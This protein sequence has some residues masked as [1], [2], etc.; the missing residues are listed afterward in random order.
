MKKAL[1]VLIGITLIAASGFK[2]YSSTTEGTKDTDSKN[3]VIS[4][5]ADSFKDKVFNYEEG[6]QWNYKGDVPAILDFYADWCGPCKMLSPVLNKIQKEYDG[7]L[8]IYKIN[9]DEQRELAATFGIRSLPTIVFV[10]MD[11]EPQATMGYH[12]KDDLEEMIT[13]ILQVEK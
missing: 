4:L 5:D 13:K 11:G 9:T 7:K 6:Q 1:L 10:P 2:L 3:A 12:S 8:Q